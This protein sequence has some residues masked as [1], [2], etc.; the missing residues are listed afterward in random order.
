[1]STPSVPGRFYTN[2][3]ATYDRL[4]L[5]SGKPDAFPERWHAIEDEEKKT[6]ARLEHSLHAS[7]ATVSLGSRLLKKEAT[8]GDAEW[9]EALT[10]L[11][12]LSPV[13]AKNYPL[14]LHV[15]TAAAFAEKL[16]RALQQ[17]NIEDYA[18]L[19][20][21]TVKIQALFHDI[22]K[23]AGQFGYAQTEMEGDDILDK[24]GMGH[25]AVQT[26]RL[27]ADFKNLEELTPLEKVIMYADISSGREPDEPGRIKTYEERV[28]KHI[29]TRTLSDHTTYSGRMPVYDAEIDGLLSLDRGD[30]DRYT[31]LYQ[32]LDAYFRNLGI[33]REALCNEIMEEEKNAPV[34]AVIFDVGG[35]LVPD[36]DEADIQALAQT[37]DTNPDVIRTAWKDLVP[38]L[39][40]GVLSVDQFWKALSEKLH[41]PIPA[42]YQTFFADNLQNS[43][44]PSVQSLIARLKAGDQYHLGI[45]TNTVPPAMK[46]LEPVYRQFETVTCSPDIGVTKSAPHAAYYVAA[47]KMNLPTQACVF[48]DNVPQYVEGAAAAGMKAVHFELGNNDVA[49]LEAALCEK[50]VCFE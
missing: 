38:Q 22:G 10:F 8:L 40:T 12:E 6:R 27:G 37:F 5:A 23:N 14:H 35:V 3:D 16:L 45:L 30:K 36:P 4:R 48:I 39:Q 15:R 34:Q 26:V 50:G 49:L 43:I 46:K 41:R 17:K 11:N 42:D 29:A 13:T 44:D 7:L 25:M 47:L 21:M 28:Q 33:D 24:V 18:S 31:V 19:D 1:M 9:N 2:Q 20:G 32:E